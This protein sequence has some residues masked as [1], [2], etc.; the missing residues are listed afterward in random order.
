MIRKI[1]I[2]SAILLSMLM[3]CN[4]ANSQ[5]AEELLP[6]AIQ[7][8]EVKGEL[9]E[10]IKLYKSIVE[11]YP[12]NRPIAAQAYI[13][14]GRCYEKLGKQDAQKAYNMVILDY[15]DQEEMV[16][17]AKAR[18]AI[19]YPTVLTEVRKEMTV[20]KVWE[21]P[22]ADFMGEPSPDGK[23]ISYVDWDSGNLAIYDVVTGKKRKLTSKGTWDDP[24]QFAEFSSWSPDGKF[25]VYDWYD[26]ANPSWIDLYIVGLD[27]SEP[28]KLWSNAEMEWAIVYDWSPDGKQI[29]ACL[30]RKDKVN[31]I[32]LISV[33]DGTVQTLKEFK[34][35]GWLVWPQEMRFS[36]DGKYIAYDIRQEKNSSQRDIY[37]IPTNGSVETCVV[38]HPLNDIFLGWM[39]DSEEIFFASDRNGT[40][41]GWSIQ[42]ENG[43]PQGEPAMIK[44]ELG[45]IQPMGFTRDASYYYGII[46]MSNNVEVIELDPET[47]EI[48]T[49]LDKAIQHFEGNN[50]TPSYSRDGKS[51]AF[52]RRYPWN[53]GVGFTYGGNILC[54]KSLETGREQEFRPALNRFGWPVWSPDGSSVLVVNWD[55]DDQM[56]YERIDIQTGLATTLVP[57]R[58]DFSLFGGHHWSLDGKTIYYGLRDLTAKTRDIVSKELESGREKTIFQSKDG[59]DLSLSPDGKWL[60]LCFSGY[61]G[62]AHV[63]IIPIS[64]GESR[65]LISFDKKTTLAW[66]SSLTWTV[67]GKY[68]LFAIKDP[69]SKIH[70]DEL[71][72]IPVDGG[73]LKKLGVKAN[74]GFENLNA[75]PNGRNF[76][77]S[78]RSERTTKIWVM[79]NF[80]P[81]AIA[82]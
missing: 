38:N 40:M 77:Y 68:I 22:E 57:A 48:I 7:L 81:Q 42:V 43:I 19:L 59:F 30:A 26:D 44:P 1:E 62:K 11:E 3:S 37:L 78:S 45:S 53:P 23:Y 63:D 65:E 39:P 34:G 29:L 32:A 16:K 28:R 54:I 61:G 14:M 50:Q 17:E 64:G 73:E 55:A 67:D 2:A 21:G 20:R 31:T 69:D 18:L 24:I 4:Q 56:S 6:E 9:E 41:G 47:G 72:R 33:A 79:E 82:K 60:A 36:P 71:Y 75:H 52:V 70:Q 46:R 66:N 58:E 74:G 5:T 49:H 13:H 35:Q 51:M 76:T 15:A 25:L 80:L 8:E 12:D 10:A 27:G